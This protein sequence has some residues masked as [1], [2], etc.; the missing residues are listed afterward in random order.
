MVVCVVHPLSHSGNVGGGAYG[1]EI[2]LSHFVPHHANLNPLEGFLSGDMISSSAE[3]LS[4]PKLIDG[5]LDLQ[6]ELEEERDRDRR[7]GNDNDDATVADVSFLEHEL[8]QMKAK[9]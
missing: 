5:W 2:D 9:K 1:V 4:T 8:N 7:E 6:Q 3:V